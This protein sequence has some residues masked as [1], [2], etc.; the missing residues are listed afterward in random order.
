MKN[1]SRCVIW[2]RA[3]WEC[4]LF[5]CLF[6]LGLCPIP[7]H[8]SVPLQSTVTISISSYM[9][10]QRILGLALAV[11]SSEA[12][13]IVYT[14]YGLDLR[15][16]ISLKSLCLGFPVPLWGLGQAGRNCY[17]AQVCSLRLTCWNCLHWVLLLLE[18]CFLPFY[19]WVPRRDG[20]S[21]REV[22]G[23]EE[24]IA[25]SLILSPCTFLCS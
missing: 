12:W 23:S 1:K 22:H 4:R 16:W 13:N 9:L 6:F 17:Y 5:W 2:I 15:D 21:K 11:R 19:S 18:L 10:G 25:F 8:G 20:I 24:T 3:F 14:D 7:S